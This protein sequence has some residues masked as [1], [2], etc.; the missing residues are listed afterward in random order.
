MR[1]TV[2]QQRA[3][4]ELQAQQAARRRGEELTETEIVAAG[5]RLIAEQ[6]KHGM[7]YHSPAYYYCRLH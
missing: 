2:D 6:E 4:A 7:I 1:Y 5:M 3:I